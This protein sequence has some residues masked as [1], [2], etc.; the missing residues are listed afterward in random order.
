MFVFWQGPFSLSFSNTKYGSALLNPV[1]LC[2]ETVANEISQGFEVI[3]GWNVLW[4]QSF[5]VS[6]QLEGMWPTLHVSS[7][8]WVTVTPR[9]SCEQHQVGSDFLP[10][11]GS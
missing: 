4:E 8:L 2:L 9:A 3:Y 11:R 7:G 6:S 1:L 5:L 10:T